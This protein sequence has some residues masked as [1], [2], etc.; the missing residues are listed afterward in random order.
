MSEPSVLIAGIGNIF[1]GDDGF[2]VAVAQKLAE[3]PLPAHVRVMEIGIRSVDLAF[4]LLEN[5]D[6]VIL[7]DA[8]QRAGAPGTLYTIEI[9]PANVPDVRNGGPIVNSHAFDPVR[10][11]A[12]AK[13]MGA[14]LKRILLVGCEPL[15]LD[16]EDT[17]H[18]G[19]SEVVAAAIGPA[20][21]MIRNLIA[22]FTA[23]DFEEVYSHERV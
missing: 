2:G 6:L 11:L 17:G 8:T 23:T 19:L 7:I 5:P 16:H 4:A 3:A 14:E 21:E 13:S 20:V 10:V 9:E 12:F 1:H 15:A 22:Q 18:I